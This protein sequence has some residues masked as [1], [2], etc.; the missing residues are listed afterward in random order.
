MAKL[1][2]GLVVLL[3]VGVLSPQ[4]AAQN[5]PPERGA[6][7]SREVWDQAI[8]ELFP[9]TPAQAEELRKRSTDQERAERPRLAPGSASSEAVTVSL[10]PGA[11]SPV[12]VLLH[13][14][15]SAIEVLDATG[16]PW[17]VVSPRQGDAEAIEVNVV[18]PD[19]GGLGNVLTVVPSTRFSVTNL[20][21]VLEGESRPVSVI[22]R[23]EEAGPGAA[24]RDRITLIVDGKGPN[25][26][27]LPH[28]GYSHLDAGP[29][30]RA[31]LTGQAPTPAA[32]E[33]LNTPPGMRA[34]REGNQLWIR[35]REALMS[36]APIGA[37]AIGDVRAY[38]L[39]YLPVLVMSRDGVLQTVNLA[40]RGGR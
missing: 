20:I 5:P 30:L 24:L 39:A 1:I 27:A 4:V 23:A 29:D 16:M 25:A 28:N 6:N 9:M 7:T 38:K 3:G 22:V 12:V 31:V 37:V 32:E 8:G 21:L 35:T 17:P 10:E 15:A 40:G 18:L 2:L 33:L 19:S 11:A 13:G 26:R 36:P 34:W 14:F